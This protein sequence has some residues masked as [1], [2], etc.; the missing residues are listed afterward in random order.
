MYWQN[1][2]ATTQKQNFSPLLIC[3]YFL[4]NV[5][6]IT[7]IN[8]TPCVFVLYGNGLG[9]ER[10]IPPGGRLM[11]VR[12]WWLGAWLVVKAIRKV[13]KDGNESKTTVGGRNPAPV[14]VVSIPLFTRFYTSQVV[15]DFFH[16]EYG[17]CHGSWYFCIHCLVSHDVRSSQLQEFSTYFSTQ[18]GCYF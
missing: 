4:C 6:Y 8:K 16:Q 13:Q 17:I 18:G 1:S 14:D 2:K 5:N 11:G 12:G 15:Q 9:L 3:C 7:A 10:L